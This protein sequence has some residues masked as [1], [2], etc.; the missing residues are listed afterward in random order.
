MDVIIAGRLIGHML[1]MPPGIDGRV[2]SLGGGTETQQ[3]QEQ[4][5]WDFHRYCF[6]QVIKNSVR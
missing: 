6:F 1:I 2:N 3:N 5:D 4:E